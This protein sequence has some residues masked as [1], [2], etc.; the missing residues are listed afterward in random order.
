VSLSTFIERP[1]V[2]AY[3]REN[4]PK[5]WFQ[6]RAEIMAPPLT[7]APGWSGCAF[8]YVLRFYIQ[9][10]NPSAAKVR[11]WLA[12]ESLSLLEH[13]RVGAPALKRARGIVETA[14]LRHRAYL[15]SKRDDK[16]GEELILAAIDL[17]QLDLVYR[18]G[19]LELNPIDGARVQDVTNMLGLVRADD[20]RA[21]RTCV[22]NPTFGAAS[23]LVGGADADL[24]IDGT[25][26]DIKTNRH[27]E[28]GRDV[29]N[30]IVGYY[31]LSLIG[32]VDGCRGK[33][34]V[35]EVA[36]Y[37]A[38]FGVLHRIP[39]SSFM[40]NNRLPAHLAWFESECRDCE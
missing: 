2:K 9:K 10:L 12:E 15:K 31:F 23:E 1:A 25:L 27:L 37:F 18:I 7:D 26:I 24:L 39:V 5:P 6:V 38:R 22:L 8:D 32:G 20:F 29:F 28:L 11:R 19:R 17:A 35:A 34:M 30:Q 14:K 13:S 36:I 3:L 33:A 40:D 4:V 16:P 21:K